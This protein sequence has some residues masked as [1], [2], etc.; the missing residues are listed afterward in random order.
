[1]SP[2]QRIAKLTPREYQIAETIA[3]G[4]QHKEAAEL[5]KISP[6]TVKV[7]L[8]RDIYPKLE[9]AGHGG[10]IRFWLEHVVFAGRNDCSQCALHQAMRG[11]PDLV[12]I[13]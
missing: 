1:M 2:L 7:Y 3:E 11:G 8:S 13:D 4:L 10:L 6:G 12:Q 5:L 9:V